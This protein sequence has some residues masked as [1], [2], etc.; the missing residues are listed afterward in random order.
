MW[1]GAAKN[2][3]MQHAF[4]VQIVDIL[5]SPAQQPEVFDALDRRS[6]RAHQSARIPISFISLPVRS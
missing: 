1:D 4:T 2:R 3:G 6:D 5:P